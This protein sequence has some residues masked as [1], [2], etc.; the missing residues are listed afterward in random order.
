MDATANSYGITGILYRTKRYVKHDIVDTTVCSDEEF[1]LYRYCMSFHSG[2][3]F[4]NGSTKIDAAHPGEVSLDG[5]T[6][7][8][9]KSVLCVDESRATGLMSEAHLVV[10]TAFAVV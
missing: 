9:H 10:S 2:G 5:V 7:K 6:E 3:T 1:D 4:R 8:L